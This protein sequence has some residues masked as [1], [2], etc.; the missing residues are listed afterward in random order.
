MFVQFKVIE[1][2]SGDIGIFLNGNF[3]T[4]T[5]DKSQVRSIIQMAV[6]TIAAFTGED[7]IVTSI[8]SNTQLND[9]QDVE[10]VVS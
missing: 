1:I 10:I 4:E 3:L 7:A 5:D 2:S 8:E 6:R 9:F